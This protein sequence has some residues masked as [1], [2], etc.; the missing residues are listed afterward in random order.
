MSDTRETSFTAHERD[1]HSPFNACQHK[2]FCL[3]LQREL[4]AA[5]DRVKALEAEL[6]ALKLEIATS[7]VRPPSSSRAPTTGE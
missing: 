4:S 2:G 3:H 7:V 5:L 1:I 6:A